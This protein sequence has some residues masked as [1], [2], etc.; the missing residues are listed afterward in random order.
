MSGFGWDGLDDG[1]QE[2]EAAGPADDG[3]GH[4]LV[5]DPLGSPDPVDHHP[6]PLDHPDLDGWHA[7]TGPDP[8]SDPAAGAAGWHE[9][10]S[11]EGP[12]ASVEPAGAPT[13]VGGWHDADTGTESHPDGDGT[14][15]GGADTGGTDPLP[16]PPHLALEVTPADGLAWADP[17]LLGAGD[18]GDGADPPVDPPHALLADL[19]LADG[20]GGDPPSW[21]GVG[22]SDDPAIRA[23]AYQWSTLAS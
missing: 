23:L 17:D 12:A 1:W 15:P 21:A 20:G 5:D 6:D 18:G 4:G 10:A 11:V 13:D 19:H 8:P 9:P 22:G 3:S 2:P 14:D 16:F 7:G